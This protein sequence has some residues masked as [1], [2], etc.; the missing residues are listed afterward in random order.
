MNNILNYTMKS[1][2]KPLNIVVEG[3]PKGSTNKKDGKVVD[4]E[5]VNID[6]IKTAAQNG[7]KID[8]KE[9]TN[10]KP[11]KSADKNGTND[12]WAVD[13][14]E[15]EDEAEWSTLD[16][17]N[18]S[19]NMRRVLTKFNGEGTDFMVL[20]EAGWAKTAFIEKAARMRGYHTLTVYLDKAV[21]SDLGGIPVPAERKNGTMYM[22]YSTPGWALYMAENPDKKFLLFFD[23]MN[24]A[25]PD[26]QNA[27]MPIVLK[28]E[29]CGIRFKNI[30]VGAAGNLS[31]ENE[32]VS[33]LSRPLQERFSI[34]EWETH[35][36]EAWA[37]HFK[38]AHKE[39]DSKLGAEFVNKV[40][41][42]SQY[43]RSPRAI[44]RYIYK[45]A[46]DNMGSKLIE[47][48][49]EILASLK[50]NCYNFDLTESETESRRFKQSMEAFAQFM[51]DFV[52]SGG[53]S[54]ESDKGSR[55]KSK[56]T[57]QV[58]QT[59]KEVLI[60]SLK[61]GYFYN[62]KIADP[63][64]GDDEKYLVTVE[65]AITAVFDPSITGITAEVFKKI[66]KE[67]EANGDSPK[68]QTNAEGAKEAK[69]KGWHVMEE[70]DGKFYVDGEEVQSFLVQD[71][72][73]MTEEPKQ[74][75][76]RHH[77]DD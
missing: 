29:V 2:E 24:Q 65:N 3:R 18:V 54:A 8:P 22:R 32:G 13:D 1:A 76:S 66:L 27:L 25:S 16:P 46:L 72:V 47:E 51:Y 40:Q 10:V 56:G 36:E 28:H 62:S 74:K 49:D 19:K 57:D 45:W 34:I 53:K 64:N 67:M 38:Y 12:L 15:P 63:E 68:F 69:S 71:H 43:W 59:D 52:V 35:T 23:E 37:D 60:A 4:A 70:K 39:Y 44:T 75:K 20:G 21:A 58:N 17:K 50:K 77:T 7:K 5:D 31:Y 41:E 6:A 14:P 48:P 33:E 61:K 73:K 11:G 26:V 30:I 9:A 42:L 55:K